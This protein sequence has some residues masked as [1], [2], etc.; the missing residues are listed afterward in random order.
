MSRRCEVPGERFHRSDAG[1]PGHGTGSGPSSRPDP[2]QVSEGNE[3]KGFKYKS[4][5]SESHES[6]RT[7]KT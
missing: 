3:R 6:I 2:F 7:F 4:Q 5:K 1:D